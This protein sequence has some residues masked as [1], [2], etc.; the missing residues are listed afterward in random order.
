MVGPAEAYADTSVS[1]SGL[2]SMAYERLVPQSWKPATPA[3][4]AWTGNPIPQIPSPDLTVRAWSI[5]P[6]QTTA[7]LQL[8]R[9]NTTTLTAFLHTLLVGVLSRLL[10]AREEAG[11][12]KTIA[13][14]IPVSLRRF[15]GVSPFELCDHVSGMALYT[16]LVPIIDGKDFPWDTARTVAAELQ[17]RVPGSSERL[18]VTRILLR[19]VSHESLL[20]DALGKKRTVGLGLSNLGRFP[21]R[22]DYIRAEDAKWRLESV[23]FAQSDVVRGSAFK[24]NVVGS[25]EGAT[26]VTFS[27]GKTAI[28]QGLAETLVVEMKATLDNMLG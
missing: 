20:K 7:L 21:L 17:E 28:D 3:A 23:F 14:G 26:N 11:G 13:V 2:L 24:A 27:W 16:P 4:T 9:S 25:P 18:G 6:S 15:T 10:V 12:Y 5:P 19:F 1:W 22:E 8:C